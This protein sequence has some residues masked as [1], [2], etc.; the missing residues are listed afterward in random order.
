MAIGQGQRPLAVVG[1]DAQCEY[2]HEARLPSALDNDLA[3][4][5][6]VVVVDVAVGVEQ[7]HR[8]GWLRFCINIDLL[9]Q[10]RCRPQ[11]CAR[12]ERLCC[13]PTVL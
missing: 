4:G 11:R 12:L 6:E 7:A 10:R 8:S 3:I 2:R 1:G 5:L 9:E 13:P